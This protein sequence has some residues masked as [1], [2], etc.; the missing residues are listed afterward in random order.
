MNKSAYILLVGA[1]FLLMAA[2]PTSP[3][4][5]P[6]A[7]PTQS[8]W[9]GALDSLQGELQS[10]EIREN[11]ATLN[12]GD[13]TGQIKD[14]QEKYLNL[15]KGD[16]LASDS[17]LKELQAELDKTKKDSAAA[18]QARISFDQEHEASA[19]KQAQES[20]HAKDFPVKK[21]K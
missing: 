21:A 1:G 7:P 19:V 14:W 11:A 5:I 4:A 16:E 17:K 13:L 15:Q 12:N 18:L 20:Q 6:P 3:P 2:A 9:K 10:C 8:Q